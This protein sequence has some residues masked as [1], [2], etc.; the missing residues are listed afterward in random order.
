M[1]HNCQYTSDK[2]QKTNILLKKYFDFKGGSHFSRDNFGKAGLLKNDFLGELLFV[3]YSDTN[4]CILFKS[5]LTF[6]FLDTDYL[7]VQVTLTI[8]ITATTTNLKP[9][10]V[11]FILNKPRFVISGYKLNRWL[12]V[13]IVFGSKRI[14]KFTRNLSLLPAL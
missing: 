2:Y 8:Y 1:F 6:S 14:S 13:L 9:L 12:L 10:C 5:D 4:I 3:L 11:T 7:P